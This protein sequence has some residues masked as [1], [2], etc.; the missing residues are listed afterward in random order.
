M[1]VVHTTRCP[2]GRVSRTYGF[3]GGGGRWAEAGI[4][5]AGFLGG[6]KAR[7]A[8]AL[9][10]ACGLDQAAIRELFEAEPLA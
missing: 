10:L 3:P 9:A 4:A 5:Q 8:L 2:S 7:V 1:A 6:V